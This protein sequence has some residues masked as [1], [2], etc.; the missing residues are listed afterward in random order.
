MQ[1]TWA[2]NIRLGCTT[3]M[4]K[5]EGIGNFYQVQKGIN[6]VDR[7]DSLTIDTSLHSLLGHTTILLPCKIYIFWKTLHSFQ[8]QCGNGWVQVLSSTAKTLDSLCSLL[9]DQ[10]CWCFPPLYIIL[11]HIP[12]KFPLRKQFFLSIDRLLHLHRGHHP[13]DSRHHL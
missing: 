9:I 7:N 10:A 2:T 6:Q 13:Q 8:Q 3:A 11:L 12:S 1:V 4:T 5:S